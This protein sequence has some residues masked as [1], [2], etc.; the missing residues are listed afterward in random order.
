METTIDK[1]ISAVADGSYVADDYSQYSFMAHNGSSLAID[2]NLVPT[3]VVAAIAAKEAAIRN[4]SFVVT[5]NDETPV[6]DN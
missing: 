6:S 5:I 3:N 4:G 1:A 2:K